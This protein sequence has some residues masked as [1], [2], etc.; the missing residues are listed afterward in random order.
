VTIRPTMRAESASTMRWLRPS[1]QHRLC[2]SWSAHY[3]TLAGPCTRQPSGWRAS[4]TNM[5]AGSAVAP[6]LKQSGRNGH[7]TA[8]WF[9]DQPMVRSLPGN[10]RYWC[11][12]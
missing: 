8:G 5:A 12:A 2:A 4:I 10:Q 6:P 1:E 3:S 11:R 7:K 9:R